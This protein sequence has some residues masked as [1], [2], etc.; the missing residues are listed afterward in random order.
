VEIGKQLPITRR[1]LTTLSIP[2]DVA[3]HFAI[4]PAMLV[5]THP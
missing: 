4:T 2:N 3:Q 1:A 5:T